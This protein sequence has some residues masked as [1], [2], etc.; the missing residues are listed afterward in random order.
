MPPD[1]VASNQVIYFLFPFTDEYTCTMMADSGG[2]KNV[3][4]FTAFEKL[5]VET[6]R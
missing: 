3:S 1:P 6:E 4:L 5:K 2:E